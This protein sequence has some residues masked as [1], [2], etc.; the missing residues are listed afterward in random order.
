MLIKK[1]WDYEFLIFFKCHCNNL[2]KTLYYIFELFYPTNKIVLTFIHKKTKKLETENVSS[3]FK[4]NSNI[5][6]N[7]RV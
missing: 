1:N 5:L 7:Y 2:L 3:N 4:T 6:K